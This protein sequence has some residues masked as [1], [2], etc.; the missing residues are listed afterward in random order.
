MS[1]EHA[2]PRPGAHIWKAW[3][4]GKTVQVK[5][6][7]HDQLSLNEP[8]FR[9]MDDDPRNWDTCGPDH[10]PENWR[11]KP[12]TVK[13]L[14]CRFAICKIP[15]Q[16]GTATHFDVANTETEAKYIEEKNTFIKWITDWIYVDVEVKDDGQ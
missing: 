16:S 3:A 8:E 7:R 14:S 15:L 10:E 13:N 4:D 11:I 6:Y 1:E 12:T 9:W 5:I 2:A